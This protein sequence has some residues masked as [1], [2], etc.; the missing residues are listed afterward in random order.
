MRA[1]A[2]VAVR[3]FGALELPHPVYGPDEVLI[4]VE[5][6]AI[7][8]SDLTAYVGGHTRIRL[9]TVLGHEFAGH[10]EAVGSDVVDWSPGD[11]VCAEPTFGCGTCRFCLAGRPNICPQYTVMGLNLDRPGAMAGLVAVPQSH[12]HRLPADMPIE[13][14]AIVQPLSVSYHAAVHRGVVAQG[15]SVLIMGAGPIGLGILLAAKAAGARVTVSDVVPYRLEA[16]TELG[17]D[18]VVDVASES[19]AE[20]VNGFTDGLGVDVVYEAVGGRND[21]ILLDAVRATIPGGRVVV[22][23]LK[24][25]EARIPVSELKFQ[26][27][28]VIG[29]QAHPHTFASV[30]EE[31]TS[32]RYPAE[33]LI[34]HR[35][36][37]ADA[38][39]AFE[40]LEGRADEVIKVVLTP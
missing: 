28:A 2:L 20:A 16:A 22:V 13:W 8:G 33:R 40:L 35:I 17:A 3:Q 34:T 24:M 19:L 7:C 29:S 18:L 37:F 10:I 25:P 11:R 31:L 14:G 21:Q 36:A 27:K 12:L 4:R 32:G 6:V 1:T 23:G 26:E 15:E 9:P 30:I 38:P 39:H 5:A